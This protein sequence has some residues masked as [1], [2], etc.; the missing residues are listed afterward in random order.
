MTKALIQ[1]LRKRYD[2]KFA[3]PCSIARVISEMPITPAEAMIKAKTSYFP[4]VEL[5]EALKIYDSTSSIQN[6]IYVG[7]LI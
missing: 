5:N 1:V 3:D 4:V 7:K 2:S 6:N